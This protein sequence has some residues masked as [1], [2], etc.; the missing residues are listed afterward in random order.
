[1]KT[2]NGSRYAKAIRHGFLP[3][4]ADMLRKVPFNTPYVRAM[5]KER[6]AEYDAFVK[7]RGVS[8]WYGHIKELYEDKR[9]LTAGKTRI[10]Y[11]PWKMLRAYEDKFKARF[12]YYTSPWERRART[13]GD[14]MAKAERTIARQKGRLAH[15]S[16]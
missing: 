11:D 15:G 1:M 12:P 10:I 8:Y 4:E 5:L 16:A 13:Q 14:F 2:R 6:K 9:W 7:D 3:F